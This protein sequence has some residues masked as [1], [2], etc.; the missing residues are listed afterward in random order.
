[1]IVGCNSPEKMKDVPQ[2]ALP[3]LDP[4]PLVLV[5][6]TVKGTI[7]GK[8]PPKYFNKKAK[9]E[10]TPVIVYDGGE[11][12]LPSNTYQGESVTDNYSVISH[13]L[14]GAYTT[15]EFSFE[16]KP[17][18]MRSNVELRLTL[19]YKDKKVPFDVPYKVGV[20]INVTQNLAEL[21]AR[22]LLLPHNF[23]RD[24]E[25]SAE[26]QINFAIQ[27]SDLRAG[28]LTKE[29]VM[30]LSQTIKELGT[31]GK[32]ALTSISI[33]SYASPDGPVDLNENLSKGRG[34]TAQDWLSKTLRKSKLTDDVIKIDEQ[35]TDWEGFKSM[36][37]SSNIEDKELILRVLSMYSDPDVRNREMHNLGKVFQV[38]AEEILPKLRRSK[39]V[40]SIAVKG[41]TDEEIKAIVDAGDIATLGINE[42]LYAVTMYPDLDKKA[43]LY[44][45]VSEMEGASNDVRVLN[46]LACIYLMQGRDI[47]AK[48]LL[49]RA[50]AIEAT[51]AVVLNN[52]GVVEMQGGRPA[53]AEKLFVRAT[54]A[55][56][57]VKANLGAC[58][59]LKGEWKAAVEYLQGSNTFNQGLALLLVERY[60]AATNI[61][62]EVKSA[63]SYYGLAI[64]GAR[65]GD[66]KAVLDN[67]RTAISMESKL[68]ARAAKDVEFLKFAQNEAFV[69][70]TK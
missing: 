44:F 34:K 20:G 65:N 15:K 5:G 10:L 52:L 35:S 62:N 70:L 13:D 41:R 7:T 17:E 67:L 48:D 9:L 6:T 50:A 68:K 66:E 26:A 8:F 30:K 29:D 40:A 11:L 14:G 31:N 3:K 36:V 4:N 16:Y 60:D 24:R 61:F 25:S 49:D 19:S 18:M 51:N 23:T 1:M 12:V 57:I 27:R 28:E 56:P 53:E 46:N 42:A 64:I 45:K 39:M 55:G 22:P 69:A 38:I 33:R 54:E 43:E 32:E 63:R 37:E 58:A 2:E 47:P 21:E 59:I